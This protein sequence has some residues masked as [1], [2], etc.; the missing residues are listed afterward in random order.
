MLSTYRFTN[1]VIKDTVTSF[2]DGAKT[3]EHRWDLVPGALVLMRADKPKATLMIP[4]DKI[5]CIETNNAESV[6]NG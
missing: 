5:L 2:L 6:F 3:V 1:N 4:L